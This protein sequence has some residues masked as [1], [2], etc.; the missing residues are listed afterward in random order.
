M[1]VGAWFYSIAADLTSSAKLTRYC[2]AECFWCQKDRKRPESC[3]CPIKHAVRIKVGM[4]GSLSQYL[5]GIY[6]DSGL[7]AGGMSVMRSEAPYLPGISVANGARMQLW[8]SMHINT[9]MS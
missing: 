6:A 1:S 4:Y 9:C 7:H 2:Q 5:Q 8:P 3:E